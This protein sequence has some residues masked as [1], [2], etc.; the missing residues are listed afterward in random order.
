MRLPT[1]ASVSLTLALAGCD[2]VAFDVDQPI[3]E[4]TVQ[5]SALPRPLAGLFTIPLDLDLTAQ[6]RAQDTGP[7]DRVELASMSLAITATARPSGDADDWSFID[8]IEVFV[9]PSA[10]GSSLPRVRIAHATAPGAVTT[11]RF[12]VD[13][14]DL[15]PYV[16]QGAIVESSASGRQPADDVSFDGAAVFTVYPL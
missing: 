10:D 8:D 7:V 9:R 14:V 1:L 2:L 3:R 4:Q 13:D 6:I 11:L 16:D 5:G 12:A 15:L